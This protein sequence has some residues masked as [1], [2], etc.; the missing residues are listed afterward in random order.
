MQ[1]LAYIPLMTVLLIL[2]VAMAMVGVDFTTT[3]EPVFTLG[4]PSNA[5]FAPTWGDFLIILGVVTLY[6]EILKSTRT[7]TASI[8]EHV[9][10]TLV[11][12]LFLVLFILMESAGTSTFL[13]LTFMAA[14]DV[15]A[16]FTITI[17][18]ARRDFSM[19]THPH[20]PAD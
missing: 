11:F 19:G 17:S 2:Y 18:T 10:S 5:T 13:I 12:I 8:F 15:I 3:A 1:Y 4:L 20:T 9:F 7:S 6:L 14:L 16:G